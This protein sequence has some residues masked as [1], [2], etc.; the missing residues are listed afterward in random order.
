MLTGFT[1]P[2]V[3]GVESCP[4]LTLGF[5]LPQFWSRRPGKRMVEPSSQKKLFSLPPEVSIRVVWLTVS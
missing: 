4:R 1:A 5:F 3:D 2:D